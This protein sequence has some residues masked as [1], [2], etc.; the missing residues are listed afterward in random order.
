MFRSMEIKWT[1]FAPPQEKPLI[2]KMRVGITEIGRL[3]INYTAFRAM[4]QPEAVHLLFDPVN[5]LVGL[6]PV[7]PTTP[8]AKILKRRR[9]RRLSFFIIVKDFCNFYGIDY[10]NGIRFDRVE[11]QS[12]GTLVCYLDPSTKYFR[13]TDG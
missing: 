3:T 6:K 9:D 4:G 7:Y 10:R 2:L 1:T 8:N 5:A 11:P 12:D 13:R